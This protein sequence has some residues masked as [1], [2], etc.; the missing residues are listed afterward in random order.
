MVPWKASAR[1]CKQDR[2]RRKEIAQAQRR[3]IYRRVYK[4]LFLSFSETFCRLRLQE[5]RYLQ[6]CIF[7]SPQ[8]QP[9]N[10]K[11]IRKTKCAAARF[12]R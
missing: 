8:R 6:V 2:K 10:H 5:A 11:Q 7:L 12:F 9:T 1:A 3:I 4:F